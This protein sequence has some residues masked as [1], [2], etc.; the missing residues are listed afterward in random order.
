MIYDENGF[1]QN[2]IEGVAY[3][4]A[5]NHQIVA[6]SVS[7]PAPVYGADEMAERGKRLFRCEM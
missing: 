2:E 5:H 7:L 4:L 6:K 3:V 1:T